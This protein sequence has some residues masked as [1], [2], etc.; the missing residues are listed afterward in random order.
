MTD[1]SPLPAPLDDTV[2][3]ARLRTVATVL[4]PVPVE[5]LGVAQAHEHLFCQL[6]APDAAVGDG[7]EW[8]HYGEPIRLSNYYD[9]RRDHI[10]ADD[11]RLVSVEDAI[12]EVAEFRRSG[13]GTIVD[14]TP[15]G[16]G[17][18]PAE[19]RAVSSATGVHV[20]M[21]CGYYVHTSHPPDLAARSEDDITAEILTE[22][23]DG[24]DG[25][26]I[27]P[28]VIGEIG[29]SWP[30][31]PAE[32]TVLRAAA[33]A[34][35]A[36]GVG[37]VVHPGRSPEAPLHHLR[38]IEAA[39]GDISRCVISHVDRTIF[40]VPEMRSLGRTGCYVEFDLFGVE[41]SHYSLA[42]V[43]LPNDAMRVDYIRRLL[44]DGHGDRV[45][46]SHDICNKSRLARYGGEGYAHILTRVVP[47][48]RRKGFGQADIDR[49]LIHNPAAMLVG[50]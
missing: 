30:A 3:A 8:R 24:V 18:A 26:G 50:R 5:S 21:G 32:I 11:Q 47:L 2:Q 40:S 41:S 35:S 34:Q 6:A 19:L 13:G 38:I 49:L 16:L 45:L 4:G 28:G 44:D 7:P 31:T 25:T 1:L 33:R 17:R 37:L 46:I 10:N 43:D 42:P 20:V 15:R 23:R 9:I 29:M 14:V 36:A 39:G 22:L 27:R 48:M 12:A